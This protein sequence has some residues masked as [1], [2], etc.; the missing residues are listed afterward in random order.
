VTRSAD[1]GELFNS[2][3][4]A[5]NAFFDRR[6]RCLD[7]HGYGCARE[8]C[9]RSASP[10]VV[11][12]SGFIS[13]AP[14]IERYLRITIV[15]PGGSIEAGMQR[16]RGEPLRLLRAEFKRVLEGEALTLNGSDIDDDSVGPLI[17]RIEERVDATWPTR[18]W[19]VEIW[20]AEE[21]LCQ[22]YAPYGMP[23]VR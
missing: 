13:P 12:L 11:G 9:G 16:S 14:A 15:I 2:E 21:A 7:E 18:A 3:L 20:Q 23:R 6:Y 10:R 4:D 5:A 1:I 17:D 22:V 8:K 19:F